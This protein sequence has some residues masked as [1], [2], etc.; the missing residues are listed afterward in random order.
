[1]N[2]SGDIMVFPYFPGNARDERANFA[3]HLWILEG[4]PQ[5]TGQSQV[6]NCTVLEI[7]THNIVPKD[8]Y[9]I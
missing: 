8:R 5:S 9:F 4:T 7:N 2:A 3:T 1:M 6:R